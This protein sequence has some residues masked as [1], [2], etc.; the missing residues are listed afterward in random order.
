[1]YSRSDED[2]MVP[3]E[4]SRS[5][6]LSSENAA[7]P[8]DCSCSTAV[9]F[10]LLRENLASL[11]IPVFR[12]SSTPPLSNSYERRANTTWAASFEERHEHREGRDALR[13]AHS[14]CEARDRC[15]GRKVCCN[16][17]TNS[18]QLRCCTGVVAAELTCLSCGMKRSSSTLATGQVRG[19]RGLGGR[20][21]T[22]C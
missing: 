3:K 4:L 21:T 2:G 22:A 11:P 5:R 18:I 17:A 20:G 16:S 6:R 14:V 7:R 10:Q 19:S 9:S 15:K 12:E 8:R 1:M 13:T